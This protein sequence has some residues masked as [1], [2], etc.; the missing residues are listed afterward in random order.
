M[1]ARLLIAV[2]LVALLSACA[3][4]PQVPCGTAQGIC[5][6][7]AIERA[8]AAA[9]HGV[10]GR[11]TLVVRSVGRANG[12]IFLD[13]QRDY[14]DQRN[15]A[16]ELYPQAQSQLRARLGGP[17]EKALEGRRIVVIGA[18]RRVKILFLDSNHHYS[19]K[20]YYQTHITVTR[21]NQVLELPAES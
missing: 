7:Q 17:L 19:G 18:A 2:T 13:S 20:Y 4:T 15:V 16:V 3:T 1:R 14:R 11:Y 12:L 6:M 21:G 9:P 10:P 8:A 5:P